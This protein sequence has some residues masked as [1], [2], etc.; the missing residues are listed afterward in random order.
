M[1]NLDMSLD[2]I[3][4]MNKKPG[5]RGGGA[6]PRGRARNSG[7]GPARRLPNRSSNRTTPYSVEKV[8]APETTWK[9]DM[10]A[11]DVVA[12]APAYPAP[13]ARVAA[14]ETGTK[15]EDLDIVKLYFAVN[16]F[17]SVQELF[18]EVGDLKRYSIH[19]D[20]SG[21]SKGTAEI[22]FSRR[23]DAEAAV[24][25]YNDV[26]LDG[27]AMKIEIV[28]TNIGTPAA[29]PPRSNGLYGDQ[30]GAPRSIRGGNI[31]PY[32]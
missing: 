13:G 23:R 24:K 7:P 26:E 17:V 2:D 31:N 5:G 16:R 21:R 25:R 20:R 1:S 10:F 9:H 3:I 30:I 32:P 29:L 14:I 4:K 6:N 8:Q 28:G 19:F 18:S 15:A 12:P 11:E 22:V 27:K